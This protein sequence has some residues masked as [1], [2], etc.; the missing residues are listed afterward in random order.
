VIELCTRTIVL[1]RG[2]VRFDGDPAEAVSVYCAA[3][4]DRNAPTTHHGP[5][6]ISKVEIIDE[7]NQPGT[8]FRTGGSMKV[9]ITYDS[10][11]P[12]E[13]PQFA[14]DIHRADGVYC[15][16]INTRMAG[17]NFGVLEGPGVV[18]LSIPNLTVLPGYYLASIGIL[19]GNV[20]TPYDVHLRAYP[21]SV[22]SDSR[23]FGV[24]HLDH[25]W[26]HRPG[27]VER[28][29]TSRG[30]AERALTP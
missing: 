26:E 24:M 5:I 7:N 29:A 17:Q 16:G 4:N 20:M 23:Q 8:V 10:S 22:L 3:A 19:H 11:Q 14:V 9:R 30:H 28:A 25:A 18:E 12:V 6:W 27:R 15:A 1:Q 13:R 2:S 21:F